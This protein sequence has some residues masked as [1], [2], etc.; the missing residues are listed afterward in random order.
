MDTVRYRMCIYGFYGFYEYEYEYV[1]GFF[2]QW[3]VEIVITFS[4]SVVMLL[5]SSEAEDLT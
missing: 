5:T 2:F 3:V 1:F 4:H